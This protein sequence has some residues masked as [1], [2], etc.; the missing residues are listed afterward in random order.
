[1]ILLYILKVSA[2]F[3]YK[4]QLITVVMTSMLSK[5]NLAPKGQFHI[6]LTTVL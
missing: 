1:M 3:E 4:F 6:F 5:L 2:V